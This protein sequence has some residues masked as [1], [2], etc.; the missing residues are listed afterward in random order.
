MGL[1]RGLK[2]YESLLEKAKILYRDI[3][4]GN[5]LLNNIEDD[6]F[7]INVDLAIKTD[8]EEAF[9]APSKTGTKVFMAI[10][11]LYGE[12]YSFMHDLESFFWLLFWICTH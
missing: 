10:G 1:L 12:D 7:L 3:S 6:G 9:G 4:I 11:A 8:R 2:G 5:V